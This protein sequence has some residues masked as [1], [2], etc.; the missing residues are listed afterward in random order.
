MHIS[1]TA[2][3]R[4]ILALA[5]AT[6]PCYA[7]AQSPTD[8][9]DTSQ[10]ALERIEDDTITKQLEEQTRQ[11]ETF[12]AD[13]A[14]ESLGTSEKK[15]SVDI[16]SKLPSEARLQAL[17][18]KIQKEPKNLDHYF[19]YAKVA[20]ALGSYGKAIQTYQRMLDLAPELHRVRLE[21]GVAYMRQQRFQE[22]KDTLEYVLNRQPPE[23]V[24]HN[25]ETILAKVNKELEEYDLSGSIVIGMHNDS[26]ANSAPRNNNILI[27]DTLIPLNADQRAQEDLQFFAAA[28]LNHSYKPLWGRGKEVSGKWNT[29]LTAYQS[30]QVKLD[31]L[32]IKALTLKTGSEFIFHESG[33]K[34]KPNLSFSHVSLNGYTYLRSLA[35]ELG[36]EYP[37]TK[38]I[39]LTANAKEE[40]RDFANAPTVNTYTDRNGHATQFDA[41]VRFV[42]TQSEFLDI[43]TSLRR[44]RTRRAYYD[45]DRQSLRASLTSLFPHDIFANANLGYQNTIYDGPDT[46][47]STQTR[48]DTERTQGITLGMK[49]TDT[50][51]A[52]AGYQ[53]R[54]VNSNIENYSYENHRFSTALSIRF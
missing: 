52:T 43:N 24:R 50:I 22:A 29:N 23:Q 9:G 7:L 21:L 13:E 46:L 20:E 49:L 16:L 11:E 5:V 26:N 36:A 33:L 15:K 54:N 27:F 32:D 44:E 17:E 37:L 25:I 41:G 2:Y 3:Q 51:T 1:I 42:L 8:P 35:P 12:D 40:I 34:L 48:H 39:F 18:K 4:I 53:H 38:T 10:K 14:A 45:N 19:A 30:E 47:I 6:T 31:T 28:S